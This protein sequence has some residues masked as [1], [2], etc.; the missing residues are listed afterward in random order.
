MIIIVSVDPEDPI[1][2]PY[3]GPKNMKPS[4]TYTL[5]RDFN[6]EDFVL[7]KPHDL[8]LVLIWMGKTQYDVVKDEKS[9]F[10][11]MVKVQ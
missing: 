3:C 8:S 6:G 4:T 5:F 7:V 2:R 9:A 10:F 1:Q 11:K